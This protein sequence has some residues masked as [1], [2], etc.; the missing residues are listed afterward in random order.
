MNAWIPVHRPWF[1]SS[2]V[3]LHQVIEGFL[4]DSHGNEKSGLNLFLNRK[5]TVGIG[6]PS[7]PTHQ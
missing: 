3:Q 4:K 7:L 2:G 6:S 1:E 5:R